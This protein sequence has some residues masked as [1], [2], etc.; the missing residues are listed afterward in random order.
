MLKQISTA[1]A[2]LALLVP[3]TFVVSGCGGPEAVEQTETA[4]EV[5]AAPELT[6]EEE[7]AEGELAE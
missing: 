6:P 2:S 7:E 5:P 3:M 1:A 4:E